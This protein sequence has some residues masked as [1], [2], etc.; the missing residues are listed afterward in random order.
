MDSSACA[1][2]GAAEPSTIASTATTATTT[3]AVL[4]IAGEVRRSLLLKRSDGLLEVAGE[5]GQGLRSVLDVDA[6]LEAADLELAPGHL[7]GHPHAPRAVGRDQDRKS[8]RLNSSHANT[9]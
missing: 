5:R 1:R 4:R 9:S 3:P 2:A 8:T 7:L 6:G